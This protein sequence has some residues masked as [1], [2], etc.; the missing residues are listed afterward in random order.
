MEIC[1]NPPKTNNKSNVSFIIS[2]NSIYIRLIQLY[3]FSPIVF[4]VK[5]SRISLYLS[6]HL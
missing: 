1:D 4:I 3:T 5:D 2:Y 6:I